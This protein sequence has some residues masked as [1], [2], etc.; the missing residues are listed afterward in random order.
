MSKGVGKQHEWESVCAAGYLWAMPFDIAF[1]WEGKEYKAVVSREKMNGVP[2]WRVTFP[3][4]RH[5]SFMWDS[6]MWVHL[7][8]PDRQM[9]VGLKNTICREI[10]EHPQ[11]RAEMERCA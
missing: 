5:Y 1:Q 6:H 9:P 10:K 2:H 8:H 11:Y 7:E 3:S 4:G